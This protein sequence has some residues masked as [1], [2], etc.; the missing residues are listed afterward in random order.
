MNKEIK[1][2]CQKINYKDILDKKFYPVWFFT[3][4]RIGHFFLRL[5]NNREIRKVF[6]IGGGGDFAFSLLSSQ[7]LNQINEVNLCDIR[8]MANVLIDFKLA[9]FKNLEYEEIID[10]FLR[11]KPL[12]KK[13]IY[14]KIRQMINLPS[15]KILDSI[16]EKCK[17]D[18]FLKCLR[19][20]KLWYRDSFWQVK[21]RVDY[22]PYLASKEKYRLLEE[23][24]NKITIYCG[25]FNDNLKLFQDDY[26]DLIYV[27]NI[28]DSKKYC[29]EP[30][31]YLQT[32]KE[33]LKKNG[34]L[35]VVT[36][37]N[38][39]KSIK[40]ITN[41]GFYLWEKEIHKFKII[42]SFFGHYSYSFLLFKK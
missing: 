39:K 5:E 35:F 9:L 25:D 10:L 36:Q 19:R 34:L 23:N 11:Q 22:L 31:L 16:I 33:K 2:I 14:K 26:Y 20:S 29:Q 15:R 38:P 27:S 40:L 13:K 42:P 7:T 4:E 30:N 1:Q 12:S 18:D 41:K 21:N 24:L 37:N 28:F 8:Q 3:N 32:I 6:S 17:K